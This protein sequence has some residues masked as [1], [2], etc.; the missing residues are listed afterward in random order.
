MTTTLIIDAHNL[1]HRASHA[2]ADL[3]TDDGRVFTGLYYGAFKMLLQYLEAFQPEFVW[4]VSDPN[5]KGERKN[6]RHDF[7]PTYKQRQIKRNAE[8]ERRVNAIRAQIPELKQALLNTNIFWFEQAGLEA[9]EII[10]WLWNRYPESD[11]TLVSTDKDMFTLL[12]P[13]FHIQYPGQ[14]RNML[15]TLNSFIR[16]AADFVPG[17]SKRPEGKK[18]E[19]ASLRE[20]AEYRWLTG[21]TSDMISGLPSCGPVGARKILDYGGY[22]EF[23]AAMT[24][25]KNPGKK[26]L[27]WA[28]EEA[29]AIYERNKLLMSINPPPADYVLFDMTNPRC[30]LGVADPG[31]LALWMQNLNF[32]AKEDGLINRLISSPLGR[33]KSDPWE[34]LKLF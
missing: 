13:N 21:D 27:A 7:L 18:I 14:K 19:F 23:V 22:Y 33:P 10:G 15:L 5:D 34:P 28:S 20:W 29:R 1:F 24:T 30:S 3:W 4:L 17:N 31:T 6:W 9:D 8:D 12:R 11:F 32:S 26:E 25:K 16:Y 2:Y